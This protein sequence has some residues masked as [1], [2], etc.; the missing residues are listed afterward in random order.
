MGTDHPK[1][2][3]IRDVHVVLGF[4]CYRVPLDLI[5]LHDDEA[6][7]DALRETFDSLPSQLELDE[8]FCD[9]QMA[10]GH[11]RAFG[12]PPL[13]FRPCSTRLVLAAMPGIPL[14]GQNSEAR[15]DGVQQLINTLVRER[16]AVVKV[17]S[18]TVQMTSAMTEVIQ[19]LG[20]EGH[21]IITPGTTV[22]F[23]LFAEAGVRKHEARWDFEYDGCTHRGS[24]LGEF[25]EFRYMRCGWFQVAVEAGGYRE[26]LAD[27]SPP[28]IDNTIVSGSL[29][30]EVVPEVV[31]E[32]LV[33]EEYTASI[34]VDEFEQV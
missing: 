18:N 20:V 32:T 16:A 19:Y 34:P 26:W 12:Q 24:A 3:K 2:P 5:L 21:V 7:V 11:W 14:F 23:Q 15:E 13:S 4:N 9:M 25:V 33:L 10:L 31:E 29:R 28:G 30:I 27:R 1:T 17:N 22:R 6:D 8:S